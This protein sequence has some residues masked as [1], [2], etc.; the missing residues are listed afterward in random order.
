MKSQKTGELGEILAL[1][2]LQ[3]LRHK[4]VATNFR[5]KKLGEIDIITKKDNTLHF[6]E[7]K[8]R[9]NDDYGFPYEAVNYKKLAKM[10]KVAEVFREQTSM[11]G[12]NYQ[13]DIVSITLD[14]KRIEYF[15]N[16]TL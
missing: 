15:Q 11:T 5:Y 4:L 10:I 1:E 8:T 9:K 7:V 6:T 16:V 2:Y 14:I 3:K 13:F 12:L